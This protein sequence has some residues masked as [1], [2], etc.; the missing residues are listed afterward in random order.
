MMIVSNASSICSIKNKLQSYEIIGFTG[1]ENKARAPYVEVVLKQPFIPNAGHATP[2]EI[3]DFMQS[4]GFQ[5]I[6]N[7]TFENGQYIVSDLHPRNVLKDE[8]G[9]ICY[10]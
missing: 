4:R 10:R 7:H 5:K 2:Q 1:F 8:D 6:N 9:Y 3:S